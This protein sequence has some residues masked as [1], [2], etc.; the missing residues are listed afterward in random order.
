[1]R[2]ESPPDLQTLL[3]YLIIRKEED[4]MRNEG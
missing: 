2:W 3:F 1:M 4:M